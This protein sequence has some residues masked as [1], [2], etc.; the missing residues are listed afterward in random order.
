MDKEAE[1]KIANKLAERKGLDFGLLTGILQDEFREQATM[2]LQTL[3]EL[4]Y[5]KPLDR[6]TICQ[7]CPTFEQG[8]EGSNQE[9][10]GRQDRPKLRGKI[11]AILAKYISDAKCQVFHSHD[12]V[13]LADQI[14][15]LFPDREEAD[16]V[17]TE[18]WNNEKDAVY[19][20]VRDRPKLRE[21]IDIPLLR[22][23]TDPN[24]ITAAFKCLGS[25][26]PDIVG[27]VDMPQAD[28]FKDKILALFPEGD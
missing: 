19:D 18:L 28:E 25:D 17:L 24:F 21:K 11:S 23:V 14:L 5:R 22:L 20:K 8:C 9:D 27:L 7:D 13:F 16:Q 26:S 2:A 4:G 3:A 12:D 15:A 6:P 10:C 1:A